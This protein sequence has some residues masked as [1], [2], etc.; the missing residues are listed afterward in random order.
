MYTMS[1][2]EAIF[3]GRHISYKFRMYVYNYIRNEQE[4]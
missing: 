2:T 1:Q 4:Q 3:N